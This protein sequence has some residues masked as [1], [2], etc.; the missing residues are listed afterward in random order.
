MLNQSYL[1]NRLGPF[2]I[3]NGNQVV[4]DEVHFLLKCP[5]YQESR[6]EFLKLAPV[7]G[8]NDN[9]KFIFLMSAEGKIIRAVSKFCFV[10]L[11]KKPFS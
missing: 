2:C 5:K 11:P 3:S 9:Q 10:N 1:E 6:R 7:G 8:L 4:E